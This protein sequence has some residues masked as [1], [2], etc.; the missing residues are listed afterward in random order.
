M[1]QSIKMFSS[2]NVFTLWIAQELVIPASWAEQNTLRIMPFGKKCQLVSLSPFKNLPLGFIFK[3]TRGTQIRE[4]VCQSLSHVQFFGT[5]WTVECQAPLSMEFSRQEYWSGLSFPSSGES[6]QPRDPTQVSHFAGRSLL[7]ELSEVKPNWQTFKKK[8]LEYTLKDTRNVSKACMKILRDSQQFIHSQTT[9]GD[10]HINLPE[11]V[12]SHFSH[13]QLLCDP[14]DC[15][16][17]ASSVHGILQAEILNWV[18]RPSS[19][20]FLTQG[21]NPCLLWLLHC[22]WILYH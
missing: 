16:L 3:M 17:S 8:N 5:P 10:G 1:R 14:V 12:L 11:C 19:R 15:S 9:Q 13:V 20:I 22:R 4:L 21:S 6:S 7:S 2:K 18:A